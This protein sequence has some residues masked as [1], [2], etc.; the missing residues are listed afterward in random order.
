MTLPLSK[1]LCGAALAVL[2]ASPAIALDEADFAAALTA[3][4]AAQ[5][6][7]LSFDSV[8]ASGTTVTVSGATLAGLPQP[9]ATAPLGDWVF[10]G[11]REDGDGYTAETAR[12]A[13]VDIE[14]DEVRV[15]IE[16]M[17]LSGLEIP[18]EEESRAGQNWFTYE[19][20]ESGPMTFNIQGTD[21]VSAAA[22]ETVMEEA[23]DGSEI[24]F[25]AQ[26][27]DIAINLEA[28]PG[29][30]PASAATIAG[31]GLQ[32]LTG[33]AMMSGTWQS[34]T[35]TVD[36]DEYE[37][38]F[39]DVGSLQMTVSVNGYTSETLRAIQ[40][41]QAAMAASPDPEAAAQAYGMTMMGL[42]QSVSLNGASFRFEDASITNRALDY[43][44]QQQG[45]S[46]QQLAQAIKAMAPMMLA[47][48]NMPDLQAQVSA[49]LNTFLD[50]P[51]SLEAV[52]SPPEPVSMMQLIGMGTAAPAVLP[53]ILGLQITAN[54]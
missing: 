53:Q 10:E 42:M 20:A 54:Q 35:G 43:F 26:V 5:G 30:D 23:E 52:A 12:F 21:V 36:I 24:S 38:A 34:D 11:V 32:Q 29:M 17:V 25:S 3:S 7:S 19:R 46:G 50:D 1:P 44:G 13:D 8:T 22:L 45:L 4:F 15:T 18:S 16:G 27:S 49:A 41:A 9:G 6:S 14:D 33:N 39:D 2:I 47:Q 40:D 37:L 51:R 28:A 31:L 48:Q